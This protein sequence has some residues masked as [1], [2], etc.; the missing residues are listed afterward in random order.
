MRNHKKAVICIGILAAGLMVFFFVTSARISGAVLCNRLF[1]WSESVNTY[2]YDRLPV[3]Q[4]QSTLPAVLLL[5]IIAG[6]WGAFLIFSGRRTPLLFTAAAVAGFQVYF[7][8]SFPAWVNV[9]L[10]AGLGLLFL[11][12]PA[13]VRAIL[14]FSLSILIVC[15]SVFLLWPGVDEKTEAVSERLRDYFTQATRQIQLSASEVPS[16][17]M[18]T[19]HVNTQS[20]LTGEEESQS[21]KIYRLVT[22]EEEQISMPHWINYL[23]ILMLLLLT[24]AVVIVPFV[25]FAILNS[26]RKKAQ[27]AR[28]AFDS[29]DVNEAVAAMFRHVIAWLEATHHAPGNR[30]FR[31]WTDSLMT[32]LSADYA[33]RFSSCADL[34]E[35]AVYSDHVLDEED[36]ESMRL[37]LNE[38][39]SILY[40]QADWKQRLQMKYVECLCE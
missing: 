6:T 33:V 21:G 38:T 1:D 30:L 9:L 34:F 4:D 24:V 36:R 25:P 31:D 2:V 14:C 35:E 22:V 20:L 29:D 40:E 17:G 15:L 19:R 37:L 11:P 18:E 27:E 23:K 10:F 26:R 32:Q 12:R 13:D 3:P 7:G 16:D 39:E 8:V 28:R 5:L